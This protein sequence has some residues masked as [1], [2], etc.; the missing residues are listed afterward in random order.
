MKNSREPAMNTKSD[1]LVLGAT[2]S[3]GSAFVNSLLKEKRAVTILVRNRNKAL[4]LYGD[5]PLVEIAEGDARDRELVA[6]LAEGKKYIFHGVN[7]PYDKW[8]ENVESVARNVIEAAKPNR[9]MIL[10]PGNIYNFGMTTPIYEDTPPAP[11][12]RKGE[13]RV[14]IEKMMQKAAEAGDCR[15]LIIRLPDF[16]GP[17]VTNGLMMPIFKAAL[18]D[19]PMKWL[20]R[21]DIPHQLAYIQDAGDLFLKLADRESKQPFEVVNF[22]GIVVDSIESW[23]NGIAKS[24][25][26]RP[27]TK[28]IRKFTL[29]LMSPFIPVIHE[30]KEMLYL[31]ENN[32]QLNDDK[33][34]AIIPDF[35]PTT[36]ESAN[37]QTLSWFRKHLT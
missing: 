5:T 29:T 30:L 23:F 4:S 32:I 26:S 31:F 35:K 21:T 24:A 1:Y 12:A 8:E 3:I 27:K 9:A 2:G 10:F 16:F 7:F 22:G 18:E 13:I 20:V 28:A 15:V 36:M 17:N 25:G 14:M 11:V 37:R 6:K 33:L 34:K 19:K